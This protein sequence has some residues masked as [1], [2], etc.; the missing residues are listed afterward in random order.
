MNKVPFVSVGNYELRLFIKKG[1]L[2]INKDGRRG[3]V[4]YGTEGDTRKEN[5]LL[6][7]V[8]IKDKLFL[9]AIAGQLL[10]GWEVQNES[11]TKIDFNAW[12]VS[13]WSNHGPKCT[14]VKQ[15]LER[16]YNLGS[17]NSQNLRGEPK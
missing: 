11:M 15:A 6:G 8:K 9:V 4:H 2:V 10:S 13:L 12:A 7:F 17:I 16:A 3:R 5:P 1:D 14:E